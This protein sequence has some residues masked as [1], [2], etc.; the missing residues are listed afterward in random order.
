MSGDYSRFGFHPSKN[1]ANV[2]LQQGRPLTDRDWNDQSI[3]T[4]RRDQAVSFDTMGQAV[5]PAATPNGF[6]ITFDNSGNLQ[7]GQ[8]R[9]YVDGFAVENHG[10]G[11]PTW[12]P[13]LAENFRAGPTPYTAQP[14][15]PKPP[16]LPASGQIAVAYLDVW[17]REVTQYEDALLVELALGVDTTT[18]RQ[19]V[20]QA[21][22]IGG[23]AAGHLRHAGQLPRSLGRAS[24]LD[25]QGCAGSVQ[26]LH[27]PA[28]DRLFGAENQLYRVEIQQG[29]A[30]GTATFKWS[31][32]NASVQARVLSFVDLSHFVVDSVGRD[33]V[34]R[35]SDGDWI[36]DH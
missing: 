22:F 19:T 23:L 25:G 31:R 11:A 28:I 30:P 24:E 12:D 17:E 13:V 9:M 4:A 10:A 34:L 26:P 16:A 27:H 14:Y 6:A 29:G 32:D 2:L 7:I 8:G 20:W 33:D 3:L 35:F 1:Y 21:R 15:L 36:E 18:R 5:V